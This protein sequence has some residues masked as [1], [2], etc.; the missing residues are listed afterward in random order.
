VTSVQH[1]AGRMTEAVNVLDPRS[2]LSGLGTAGVF[3]AMFAETGLLIGFFLPGDSLLFTAGLFAATGTGSA[4]HLAL[5]PVVLAA[6]AGALSGAQVGYLIGRRGGHALLSRVRSRRLHDGVRHASRMLSRYGYRKTIVMAR[7]VPVVRT[8]VGPLA[9]LASVPV[10]TY[11]LWQVVGG[12]VW[13]VGVTLAG[14]FLGSAIPDV[15][16]YLL[17]IIGF[18]VLVSLL[19]FALQVR[20]ARKDSGDGED[21]SG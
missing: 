7:F 9:G 2:M 13:T 21:S 15:D 16:R 8:V 11:A 18:V 10:R 1:I 12:L 5:A 3:L 17:P 6:A 4:V 14:Y 20:G 19:P